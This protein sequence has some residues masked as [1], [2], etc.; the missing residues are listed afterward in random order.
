MQEILQLGVIGSVVSLFRLLDPL[1][2]KQVAEACA[3]FSR[4]HEFRVRMIRLGAIPLLFA[5]LSTKNT[6]TKRW[7]S[8]ALAETFHHGIKFQKSI[9]FLCTPLACLFIDS[10]FTCS[11][12]PH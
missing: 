12:I 11:N 2:R 10:A 3:R 7:A 6:D 4:V 8:R 5:L 9:S 1:M